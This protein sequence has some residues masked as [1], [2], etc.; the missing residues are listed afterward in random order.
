MQ[1]LN[2]LFF[3]MATFVIIFV[4]CFCK[5]TPIYS[6][7]ILN[8]YKTIN[9]G[10]ISVFSCP[11]LVKLRPFYGNMSIS[12]LMITSVHPLTCSFLSPFGKSLLNLLPEVRIYLEAPFLI[13]I[14][15]P[16]WFQLRTHVHSQP[17][18]VFTPASFDWYLIVYCTIPDLSLLHNLTDISVCKYKLYHS[19]LVINCLVFVLF[20]QCD[21]QF[22]RPSPPS[23]EFKRGLSHGNQAFTHALDFP[24][25][26][27]EPSF[28]LWPAFLGIPPV[29][30]Q[31]SKW[32]THT[33]VRSALPWRAQWRS[34]N[35]LTV[36]DLIPPSLLLVVNPSWCYLGSA[37]L[38]LSLLFYPVLTSLMFWGKLWVTA[39]LDF[40]FLIYI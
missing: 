3:K 36:L 6:P 23:T 19:V 9:S 18:F 5:D 22:S 8:I 25:V 32:T 7:S 35:Q 40:Y 16:W 39:T 31:W 33:W 30:L 20:S 27:Q 15:I 17:S 29:S 24:V 28:W 37:T 14:P 2:I 26:M 4:V 1:F 13:K 12:Y 11:L 21:C 34:V 38:L 10:T